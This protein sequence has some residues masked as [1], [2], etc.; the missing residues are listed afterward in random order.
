MFYDTT[1]SNERKIDKLIIFSPRKKNYPLEKLKGVG[2]YDTIYFEK[3]HIRL[4]RTK[5]DKI[6]DVGTI[7]LTD[8]GE[9]EFCIKWWTH[10]AVKQPAFTPVEI[11]V[12]RYKHVPDPGYEFQHVTIKL[13]NNEIKTIYLFQNYGYTLIYNDGSSKTF[14]L[15]MPTLIAT[16]NSFRAT[17]AQEIYTFFMNNYF[18]PNRLNIWITGNV[19]KIYTSTRIKGKKPPPYWI[20]NPLRNKLLK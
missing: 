15:E 20:V 12:P 16:L 11:F 8:I 13:N 2:K 6:I 4:T 7:L 9:I 17:V 10:S 14:K 1:K 19:T 3:N 18:F 5:K